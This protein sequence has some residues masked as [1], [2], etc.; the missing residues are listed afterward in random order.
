MQSCV[1]CLTSGRDPRSIKAYKILF[2]IREWKDTPRKHP[3][4][5]W[6]YKKHTVDIYIGLQFSRYLGYRNALAS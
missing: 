6:A 2:G 3:K 1:A 5:T 4:H